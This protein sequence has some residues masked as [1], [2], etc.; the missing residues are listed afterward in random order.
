LAAKYVYIDF[1]RAF[2]VLRDSDRRETIFFRF[3]KLAVCV[4]DVHSQQRLSSGRFRVRV[5]DLNSEVSPVRSTLLRVRGAEYF[6][7]FRRNC[8]CAFVTLN[9]HLRVRFIS[10]F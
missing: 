10:A 5:S 3:C 9:P 6:V 7:V 4:P 1:I 8:L 2:C